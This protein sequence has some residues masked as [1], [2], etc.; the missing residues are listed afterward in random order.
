[1]NLDAFN[2]SYLDVVLD[3]IFLVPGAV[4]RTTEEL[5]EVAGMP[6]DD[7]ERRLHEIETL[8]SGGVET[9][10]LEAAS[11]AHLWI[12]PSP[13]HEAP[14]LE[15]LPGWAAQCIVQI[16]ASGWKVVH[17]RIKAASQATVVAQ[18]R[19]QAWSA[20]M[21]LRS[22]GLTHVRSWSGQF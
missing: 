22:R 7:V 20:A 4:V 19:K 16:H 3:E 18:T 6:V 1:M 10:V 21:W 12:D 14:R 9:P 8:A 2:I 11:A 17:E 5:A 13:S 15:R